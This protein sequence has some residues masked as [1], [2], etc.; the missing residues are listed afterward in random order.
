MV[1]F[2]DDFARTHVVSLTSFAVSIQ[3]DLKPTAGSPGQTA[4]NV[5]HAR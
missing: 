5:S 3:A 4:Q 1:G 2:L